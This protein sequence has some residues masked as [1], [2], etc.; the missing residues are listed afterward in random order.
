[1]SR[2]GYSEDLDQWDLIRWRGAVASSI[3]GKR[4]QAFLR[5]LLAA[6]DAMPVK[7]LIVGD[8]KDATGQV[9]TLGSI[10]VARG[11]DVDK[12]DP[13]DYEGLSMTFGIAEPLVREIEFENDE[14][15]QR[16][17][18]E[19]RWQRMR[20]WVASKIAG[21]VGVRAVE[22]PQDPQQEKS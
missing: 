11:L 14:C 6:L 5:E 1:M 2:C 7:A 13:D 8:L 18:P 19:M 20:D 21:E 9:C 4:G 10:G 16:H 15:A 3:R 12:L 17:T 22:S